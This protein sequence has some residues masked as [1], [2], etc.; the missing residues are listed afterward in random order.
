MGIAKPLDITT[1][2]AATTATTT[3]ATATA[4]TARLCVRLR[5]V[6]GTF[7]TVFFFNF[8]RAYFFDIVIFDYF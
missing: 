1:A 5:F 3:A 7:G 2:T 6:E 4:T 8:L